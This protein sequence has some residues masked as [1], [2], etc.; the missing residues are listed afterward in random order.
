M[1][2]SRFSSIARPIDPDYPTNRAI[3]ILTLFV[4][5]AS[6]GF[7]VLSGIPPVQALIPGVRA[8]IYVFLA[9]AL[10]RELDPDNGLSAFAAAFLACVGLL[11]F[12]VPGMLPLAL[13]LLLVRI[14]NRSTGLPAKSFDSVVILLLSS[15]FLQENWIFGAMAAAAFFLDSRLSEPNRQNLLF[16]GIA[17][18]ISAFALLQELKTGSLEGGVS[19]AALLQ[20]QGLFLLILIPAI[21]FVPHILASHKIKSKGDLSGLPLDP[22]RVQVAQVTALLGALALAVLE[23]WPGIESLIPLWSAVAGISLYGILHS[24]LRIAG[25]SPG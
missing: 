11:Y 20:E 6:A 22:K 16:A 24:L 21:F 8:G 7:Q 9:W 25:R 23:G 18:L 2:I 4:I 14:L 19:E 17:A 3:L 12:P 5:F 13:F 10:A 15:W 1:G